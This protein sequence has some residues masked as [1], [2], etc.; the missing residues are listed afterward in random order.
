MKEHYV[1]LEQAKRLHELGYDG[2]DKY[3]VTESFCYG[4]DPDCYYEEGM[5]VDEYIVYFVNED[6]ED[7]YSGV[8]A[9]RLDQAQA[10][11]REVKDVVVIAEPDWDEEIQC[12]SDY[13][14]GKWYFT[15]WKDS[16]RIRCNFDPSKEDEE[17]WLFDT[18]ES[19]LSAGIS[20]AIELLGKEDKE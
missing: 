14:T 12:L 9:P 18:Y 10:W 11:L 4:N 8:P 13:L 20:M 5:V 16:S 7:D 19:A 2:V 6:N 1:S 15:V 17:I 3:Y